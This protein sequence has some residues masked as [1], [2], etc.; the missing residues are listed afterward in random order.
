MRK[1]VR[2]K[3]MKKKRTIKVGAGGS[4]SQGLF[5]KVKTSIHSTRSKVSTKL[6]F[7][8]REEREHYRAMLKER[9]KAYAERHKGKSKLP[10]TN[11]E[12]MKRL[13][14]KRNLRG[15]RV[16]GQKKEAA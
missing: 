2:G 11:A 8:S 15:G 14:V 4:S 12:L 7:H 10:N 5:S 9:R 16:Q 3:G 6:S 13:R 1:Y